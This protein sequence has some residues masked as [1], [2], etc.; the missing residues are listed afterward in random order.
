[1]LLWDFAE[2][3]VAKTYETGLQIAHMVSAA[4]SRSQLTTALQSLK[5]VWHAQV[6]PRQGKYAC[7]IVRGKAGAANM[8]RL[9]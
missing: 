7:L 8:V 4:R 5:G 1:M 6:V 3:E 9:V 2:A